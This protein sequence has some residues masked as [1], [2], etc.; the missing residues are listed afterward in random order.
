MTIIRE[1]FHLLESVY[2]DYEEL[3]CLL[4][5]HKIDE[6]LRADIVDFFEAVM[7]QLNMQMALK[8]ANQFR[9]LRMQRQ[10]ELERQL[11]EDSEV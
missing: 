8:Q 11:A 2:D 3:L 7:S 4:T 10:D 9:L 5:V 1:D 6:A